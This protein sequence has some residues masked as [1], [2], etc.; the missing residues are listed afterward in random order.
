M[1]RV[2]EVSE[3]VAPQ[4]VAIT[5]ELSARAAGLGSL[6]LRVGVLGPASAHHAPRDQGPP[7][8][9]LAWVL[10]HSSGKLPETSG[11]LPETS[12]SLFKVVKGESVEDAILEDGKGFLSADKNS[13]FEEL[14]KNIKKDK[15]PIV[16]AQMKEMIDDRVEEIEIQVFKPTT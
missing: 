4:P 1:L 13:E 3:A 12:D 9:P 8:L 10:P 16:D 14:A 2:V 11:R 7:A 6:G 15:I 5:A